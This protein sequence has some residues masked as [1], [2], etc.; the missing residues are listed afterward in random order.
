MTPRK[1]AAKPKAEAKPEA[2]A[3]AKAA[4]PALVTHDQVAALV[5]AVVTQLARVHGIPDDAR[6]DI[7][8]AIDQFTG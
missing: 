5:T 3:S 2:P 1:T 8:A 7:Q 6:A 4:T